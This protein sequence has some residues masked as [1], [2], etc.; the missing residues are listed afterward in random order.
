MNENYLFK[1]NYLFYERIVFAFFLL[2]MNYFFA[3]YSII[4]ALEFLA[5]DKKYTDPDEFK[6]KVYK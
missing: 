5:I 3:T 2:I 4:S 6:I 1:L